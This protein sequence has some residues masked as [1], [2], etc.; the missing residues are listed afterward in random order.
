YNPATARFYTDLSLFTSRPAF[1]ED[2]TNLFNLL[3]GIC[4]FQGTKKLL[5]APFE[6]HGRLLTLID[7][8]AEHARQGLPS[9]I[10]AKMNALVDPQMIAALYAAAQ[11]G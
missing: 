5:V 10:I 11:A 6:L 8:E 4:Q 2:A 7:R 9:R 1:A 3:T